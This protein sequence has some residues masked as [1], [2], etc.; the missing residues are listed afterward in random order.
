MKAKPYLPYGIAT[1]IIMIFL[2]FAMFYDKQ[3]LAE[4]L[5]FLVLPLGVISCTRWI[6]AGDNCSQQKDKTKRF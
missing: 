2:F 4:G 1:V 3:S 5:I 6:K